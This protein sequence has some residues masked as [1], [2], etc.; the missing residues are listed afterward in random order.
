MRP[1]LYIGLR[2]KLSDKLIPIGAGPVSLPGQFMWDLWWTKWHWDRFFSES[3]GFPLSVSFHRCSI[4]THVSSGGRT[5]GPLE[6]AVPQRHSSNKNELQVRNISASDRISVS[7]FQIHPLLIMMQKEYQ[8][9]ITTLKIK[10]YNCDG[11][12]MYG[13]HVQFVNLATQILLH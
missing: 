9:D 3:F 5:M 7:P 2:V 12:S 6:A 11:E 10:C 13:S 8:K 4:F 1:S